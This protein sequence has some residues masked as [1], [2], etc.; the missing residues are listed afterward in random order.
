MTKKIHVTVC[1]GTACY[2][3]GGSELLDLV[4]NLPSDL[5]ERVDVDG[6]PCLGLCKGSSAGARPFARVDGA[7]VAD[8]TI[9]SLIDAVKARAAALDAGALE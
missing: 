3:L 1:C 5:R 7:V 4:D 8:A 6:A 9:L 2:V